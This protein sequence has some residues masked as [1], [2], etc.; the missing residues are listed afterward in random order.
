MLRISSRENQ[1]LFK[2][3][4]NERSRNHRENKS[5]QAKNAMSAMGD[6]EEEGKEYKNSSDEKGL[7]MEKQDSLERETYQ[8]KN[9]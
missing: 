2:V 1:T 3:T 4:N 8:K 5:F 6:Q 7:G 9:Y